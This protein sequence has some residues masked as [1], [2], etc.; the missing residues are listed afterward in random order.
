MILYVHNT[1]GDSDG[2]L[3]RNICVGGARS[4]NELPHRKGGRGSVPRGRTEPLF[5]SVLSGAL[6]EVM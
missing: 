1:G 6:G 5:G 2:G 4:S 3:K